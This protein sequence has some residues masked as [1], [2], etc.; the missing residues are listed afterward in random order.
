MRTPLLLAVFAQ[1]AGAQCPTSLPPGATCAELGS[2]T[3]LTL[4]NDAVFQWQNF[5]VA[6]GMSLLVESVGG[7]AF[8]STHLVNPRAVARIG[9]EV[10]A[11]GAFALNAP[12]GIR[13]ERTG[14]VTAPEVSLEALEQR[15]DGTFVG[16]GF[17]RGVTNLGRVEA[18][19]A[20]VVGG[21]FTN[22]GSLVVTEDLAVAV[23]SQGV[24]TSDGNGLSQFSASTVQNAGQIQGRTVRIFSEGFVQNSGAVVSRGEGNRLA[25]EGFQ[26]SH[27]DR[28]GS[29]IESSDLQLIPDT[30]LQGTVIVPDDGA[31]PGGQSQTVTVPDLARGTFRG[32]TRTTLL[33][34]QFSSVP[35]NRQKR[36]SPVAVAQGKSE[37]K[38]VRKRMFFSE[39]VRRGQTRE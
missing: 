19:S 16:S 31:N 23:G 36:R 15:T 20:L 21:S 8:S 13:V 14:A 39:V 4:S 33:P 6:P 9:G 37:K 38:T 1:V 2:V 24:L 25:I 17:G 28:P 22:A 32:E 26:I 35:V 34:T 11:D 3:T 5:S 12:R 18:G 27:D 10:R 30:P 7:G 29:V